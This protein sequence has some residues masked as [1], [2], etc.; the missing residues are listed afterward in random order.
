MSV[1]QLSV[2]LVE[3]N[4]GDVAYLRLLLN[5]DQTQSINLRHAVRLSDGLDI[6][7]VHEVDI[8]L[9]DLSLPDSVGFD[10]VRTTQR[11]SPETPIIV[12]T[13]LDDDRAGIQAIR[14]GAQDYLVKGRIDETALHRAIHHAMERHEQQLALKSMSLHDDLTHL[15]NRRGF[16]ILATEQLKLAQRN[17]LTV[18]L[19]FVDLDGLK[20]INDTLGHPAGNQAIVLTSSVIS[21]TA[22]ESDIV[23]RIGGDEFVVLLLGA[24][25][26]GVEEFVSRLKGKV[27]AANDTQDFPF[28]LSLSL[29]VSH[30]DATSDIVIDELIARADEKMYEEKTKKRNSRGRNTPDSGSHTIE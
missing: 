9:L 10:T 20:E 4:P 23:A 11:N 12:L 24:G 21:D 13:G 15:H 2:L 1:A 22:R 8:I 5:P 30:A 29:G 16:R 27:T 7:R 6:L 3:D 25:R 18:S 28:N 14:A 19:I 17:N 26:E